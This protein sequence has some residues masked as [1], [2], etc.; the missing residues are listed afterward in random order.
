MTPNYKFIDHTADI[1]VEVQGRTIEELFLN[2]A[3]AWRTA[4]LEKNDLIGDVE[5]TLYLECETLEQLLVSF[6]NE[7]NF[8][9]INKKW[10]T[11]SISKIEILQKDKVILSVMLLGHPISDL[12]SLKAEIKSVTYHQMN[13]EKKADNYFTRIVFDI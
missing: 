8:L 4:A 6:L 9:L 13:I 3:D 7:L 12:H 10:L 1:A 2:S 5:I 11:V